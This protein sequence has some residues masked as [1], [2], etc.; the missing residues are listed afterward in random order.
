MDAGAPAVVT[1]GYGFGDHQGGLGI[2][3]SAFI[4]LLCKSSNDYPRLRKFQ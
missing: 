3:I 2:W 1:V 4:K